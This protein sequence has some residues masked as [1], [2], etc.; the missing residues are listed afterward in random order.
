M[1]HASYSIAGLKANATLAGS[2]HVV[3]EF[4]LP[5]D[6]NTPPSNDPAPGCFDELQA[7]HPDFQITI[8]PRAASLTLPIAATA[9]AKPD[10]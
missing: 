7:L 6:L 3:V 4:S 2:S 10:S 8:S 1:E 9:G 5:A